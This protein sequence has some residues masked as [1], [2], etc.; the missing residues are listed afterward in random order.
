[1][2][3]NYRNNFAQYFLTARHCT[4][5]ITNWSTTTFCFNYQNSLCN[6]NDG[7]EYE[8]YK[9]QGSQMIGYCDVSWSDNA[10]LLI[11]EPIPIQANVY[12]AGVDITNR[13][14]GDGMTCIHH[15]MG[16]PQKIV[17]GKLQH[18]AGP[19]W[20]IYWDDGIIRG[21]G[22][23]APVFLNSNKRVVATV[24]GGFQNLDCNNNLK[25]EWVGKIKACVDYSSGIN[26]ALFGTNPHYISYSGIDPIKSCQQN[27]NLSG[28]FYSTHE[29]DA[30]L[31]GLTIQ[32]ANKVTSTATFNSDAN[33]TLTAGNEI[34]FLPGTYIKPGS[35]VIAKISPCSG[36]FIS[37]GFHSS[38]YS[39]IQ[40]IDMQLDERD[41]IEYGFDPFIARDTDLFAKTIAIY[42]NPNDGTFTL[43]ANFDP[44]EIVSIRIFNLLG[45]T[46]FEQNGTIHTQIALPNPTAGMYFLKAILQSGIITQKFVVQ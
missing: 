9:V 23:G 19:K 20:E 43:S 4:N 12:Y 26:N 25:Q 40:N 30:T 35:T 44:Q 17:S 22:S 21:G 7:G 3:N 29:Y 45:N 6:S 18:F 46:V 16:K 41:S 2:V 32:A 8:Y 14:A 42:P 33:Y 31:N 37:C 27:L 39:S 15:S 5:E 28:N 24:S 38:A 10:L 11:T 34:V 13:N 1:L 36:N